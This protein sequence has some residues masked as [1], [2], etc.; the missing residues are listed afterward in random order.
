M[1]DAVMQ[2]VVPGEVG[3]VQA[4]A[5]TAARPTLLYHPDGRLITRAWGCLKNGDIL[6]Y[7]LEIGLQREE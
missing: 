5:S 3:S 1:L 7:L 2:L 6:R 4:L